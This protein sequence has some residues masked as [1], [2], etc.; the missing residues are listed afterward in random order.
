MSGDGGWG[1]GFFAA[2]GD[3][4]TRLHYV[5]QGAGE[6]LLL[7]GGTSCN[8]EVWNLQR[9][10]FASRHDT[11]AVDT[12][13]SGRSDQPADPDYYT[14]GK[15]AA[16]VLA[17]LDHADVER[18]HLSGHSLGGAIA[19]RAALDFPN[20]VLSA[21]LHATWAAT[22]DLMG[23][24]FFRPMLTYLAA[25]DR[26]GA[27]KLGQALTMSHPYLLDRTPAVVADLV[28]RVMVRPEHPATDAGFTGHL[29]AGQAHD[30]RHRL[31][32][33]KCPVMVTVGERDL[34]VPIGYSEYLA[35]HIP[36]AEYHVFRGE[37][38][39][40]FTFWEL[41]DEFVE[42]SLG[43]TATAAS[44]STSTKEQA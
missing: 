5:R 1:E 11:I 21:Q 37:R 25:G 39:G 34:N 13:G 9:Q 33:V 44:T 22:D 6:T 36:G 24:L 31:A 28:R 3:D 40:H 10:Q 20:R 26:Y 15:M 18:A 12:R 42:V 23:G 29:V 7:I 8:H 4:G 2:N 35:S 16:D 43:F 19:L 27:F 38:S 30:E 32:D 17:V 41:P 14:I